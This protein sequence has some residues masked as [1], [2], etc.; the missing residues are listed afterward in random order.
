M[1][2]PLDRFARKGTEAPVDQM[3]GVN[4]CHDCKESEVRFDQVLEY[5]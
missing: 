2:L 4:N 1:G 3:E 5:K